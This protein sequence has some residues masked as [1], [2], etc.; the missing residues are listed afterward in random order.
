MSKSPLKGRSYRIAFQLYSED[1]SRSVDILEF[2]GGEV[3]L[4]EKEKVG[5]GGFENRHSGSLV[6]PFASA[7]AAESF[8]VGTSWFSGR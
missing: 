3:F 6:G 5:T 1:G 2:E 8:I 7:E 4:D